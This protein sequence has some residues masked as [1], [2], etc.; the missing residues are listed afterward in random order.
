MTLP[1]DLGRT[2][3]GTSSYATGI[4]NIRASGRRVLRRHRSLLPPGFLYSNGTTGRLGTLPGGSYS[5]AKG[6]DNAGQVVG[7]SRGHAFLYSSGTMTDLGTLPGG[8]DSYATGINNAGQVVG[9]SDTASGP[10]HAFLYSN[11]AMTDL[12]TLPGGNWSANRHQQRRRG[13]RLLR[14]RQRMGF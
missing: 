9:Y 2:P 10:G 7:E 1:I 3:G 5:L 11:G 14:H 6:I 4:N 8:L 13:G 12:G